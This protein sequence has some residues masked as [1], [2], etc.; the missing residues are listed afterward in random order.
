MALTSRKTYA[1][2]KLHEG[3]LARQSL[4]LHLNEELL[5][6]AISVWTARQSSYPASWVL[7]GF[8][9]Q[10]DEITDTFLRACILCQAKELFEHHQIIEGLAARRERCFLDLA[11]MRFEQYARKFRTRPAEAL[12]ILRAVYDFDLYFAICAPQYKTQP[13]SARLMYKHQ[14]AHRVF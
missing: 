4:G 7:N 13:N 1:L 11:S 8:M 3:S 14:E 6:I 10:Q 9:E 2:M 12:R 5:S